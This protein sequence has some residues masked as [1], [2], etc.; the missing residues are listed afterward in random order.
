MAREALA[1]E[2]VVAKIKADFIPV[3]VDFDREKKWAGARGV[4]NLPVIHWTDS[5]GET[6]AMTEDVKPVA[7]V[8]EDMQTALE[9]IAEFS[10]E[11]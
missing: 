7:T 2:A 3:L 6:M 9:L 8:L 4:T 11:E 10:E 5:A 1:D